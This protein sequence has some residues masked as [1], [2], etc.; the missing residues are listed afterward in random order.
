MIRKKFTVDSEVVNKTGRDTE[1][2][3]GRIRL[4]AGAKIS[5]G[6][7]IEAPVLIAPGAR[8][9][10][11]VSIGAYSYVG[12]NTI[13]ANTQISRYCSIAHDCQINYFRGHPV[14]WL[15]THPFQFDDVNF[16]FWPDY[17]KFKKRQFDTDNTQRLVTIGPDVW[18]GAKACIFGGLQIGAGAIV[19]ALALVRRDVPPYGIVVGS[20]ARTIKYRFSKSIIASLLRLKWWDLDKSRIKNLPFD[21]IKECIA[22][23]EKSACR[24]KR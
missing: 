21:N 24:K 11:D 9:L 6:T 13:V 7:V 2:F 19:G 14:D 10:R 3:G 4:G 23:L 20:P 5:K 8:I 22:I 16:A 17:S 18:M 15:S 1:I 12:R